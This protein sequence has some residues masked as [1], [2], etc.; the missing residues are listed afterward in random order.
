MPSVVAITAAITPYTTA[1]TR[2]GPRIKP[3]SAPISFIISISSRRLKIAIR[4]VLKI[5]KNEMAIKSTLAATPAF[6]DICVHS[7]MR[8]VPLRRWLIKVGVWVA[9]IN[10]LSAE[11][12]LTKSISCDVSLLSC[13]VM[14]IVA[15]SEFVASLRA[16]SLASSSL[17]ALAN[18]S[19]ASSVLMKRTD[20][21]LLRR[22]KLTSTG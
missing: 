6:C 7:A 9:L 14:R 16:F 10:G 17:L 15:G 11:F 4:M 13:R 12:V 18:C 21:T 8:V 2:N 20:S 1:S 5:I 19:L 3:R 22:R